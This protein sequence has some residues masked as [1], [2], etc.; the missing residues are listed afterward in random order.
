MRRV[1]QCYFSAGSVWWSF[2]VLGNSSRVRSLSFVW[3]LVDVC[4]EYIARRAYIQ[5]GAYF[6]TGFAVA[7]FAG[8]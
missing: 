8:K 7:L 4:G 5:R 2:R 3:R 1:M 6:C